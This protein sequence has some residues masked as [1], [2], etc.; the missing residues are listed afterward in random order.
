MINQIILHGDILDRGSSGELY[1]RLLLLLARDFAAAQSSRSAIFDDIESPDSNGKILAV[2]PV[3]LWRMLQQLAGIHA[4]DEAE[5]GQRS[6]A[7]AELTHSLTKSLTITGENITSPSQL[8]SWACDVHINFTH[9]TQATGEITVFTVD[10]L[11]DLWC[12]GAAL[13]C[14]HSQPVI[15]GFFVGYK[16]DLD[17]P[18]DYNN[19]VIIPWQT[20]YKAEA[21]STSTVN[22][23]VCP[24]IKYP[25]GHLGKPTNHLV[26]FMDLGTNTLFCDGSRQRLTF[27]PATRGGGWEGYVA[28]GEQ[29]ASRFSLNIRGLG[30]DS[31]PLLAEKPEPERMDLGDLMSIFHRLFNPGASHNQDVFAQKWK[32][33][34]RAAPRA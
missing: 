6:D 31:Y 20:K 15:D 13:R 16:G 19:F 28:K 22:G 8:R 33:C 26:I 32:R 24:P 7:L 30:I 25:D 17:A 4:D 21:A 34:L 9:F 12:R 3:T 10:E 29:E 11:M 5:S 2:I 18:F 23:L 27:G 1:S 14:T